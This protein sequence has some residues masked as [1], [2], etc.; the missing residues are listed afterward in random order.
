MVRRGLAECSCS[1]MATLAT[2]AEWSLPLPVLLVLSF[3]KEATSAQ[4]SQ[5]SSVKSQGAACLD[6]GLGVATC[7]ANRRGAQNSLVI[8]CGFL[9]KV[10]SQGEAVQD[11]SCRLGRSAA[12]GAALQQR[13]HK[14]GSGIVTRVRGNEL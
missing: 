1:K 5:L 2:G 9:V 8:M 4:I 14:G 12:M 3:T 11:S 6:R 10:E 7:G 13:S